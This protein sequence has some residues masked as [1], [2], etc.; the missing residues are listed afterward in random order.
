MAERINP[1]QHASQWPKHPNRRCDAKK[2]GCDENLRKVFCP[3]IAPAAA[4]SNII[5]HLETETHGPNKKHKK[6]RV[7]GV[8]KGMSPQERLP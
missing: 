5:N 3:E 8:D 2:E 1:N 6:W 7:F 4:L